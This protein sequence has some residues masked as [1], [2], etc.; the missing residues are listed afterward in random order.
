MGVN[1]L[2]PSNLQIFFS[3]TPHQPL[4]SLSRR[5][6]TDESAWRAS[7]MVREILDTPSPLPPLRKGCGIISG[8]LQTRLHASRG[9]VLVQLDNALT[10][11]SRVCSYSAQLLLEGPVSSK[12]GRRGELAIRHG[13]GKRESRV[14]VPL[15]LVD[16]IG[17]C[18]YYGQKRS[19]ISSIRN[20]KFGVDGRLR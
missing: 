5:S 12:E 17:R 16:S 3:I 20:G 7:E 14:G 19:Q 2:S 10:K 8:F 1:T 15:V 18:L 11:L 4:M 6:S 9:G 13:R